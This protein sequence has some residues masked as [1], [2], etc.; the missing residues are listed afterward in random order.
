MTPEQSDILLA[1]AMLV[2]GI[3]LFVAVCMAWAR[4]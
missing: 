1:M 2:F 3:P 4:S